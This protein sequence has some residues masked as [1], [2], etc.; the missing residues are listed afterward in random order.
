MRIQ[1]VH[2][3]RQA[4]RLMRSTWLSIISTS[5]GISSSIMLLP[6]AFFGF[7]SLSAF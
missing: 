1:V 2:T 4:S 6:L 5:S 7:V 3:K